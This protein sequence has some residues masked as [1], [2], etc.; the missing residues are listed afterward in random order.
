MMRLPLIGI[1]GYEQAIRLR[2][3]ICN[4]VSGHN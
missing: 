3:L 1:L 2:A 4:Y